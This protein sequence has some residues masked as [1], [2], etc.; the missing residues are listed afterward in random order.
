MRALIAEL[1]P[2]PP[3]LKASTASEVTSPAPS[4]I[5]TWLALPAASLVRVIVPASIASV[6]PPLA[7]DRLP[8]L[9]IGPP[10][11]PEPA[12]TEVTVPPAPPAT[13]AGIHC[14]PS[15]FR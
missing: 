4:L 15:H 5:T 10:L 12:P 7:I 9:V 1:P 11:R 6:T 8:V 14:V 13:A 3:R 2:V